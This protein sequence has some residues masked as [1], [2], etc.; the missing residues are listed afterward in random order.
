MRN[1]YLGEVNNDR[2]YD[3][4]GKWIKG[5]N[6]LYIGDFKNGRRHG[7]GVETYSDGNFYRGQFVDGKRHGYGTMVW[8][9]TQYYSGE[10]E[11]GMQNGYGT[12]VMP[13]G[14]ICKGYW[15][16]NKLKNC[17]RNDKICRQ[18]C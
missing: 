14:K 8:N 13:D 12:L 11:E 18:K 10:Y 5:E 1:K 9:S 15:F 7:S 3:G 2:K 6:S 16:N 4:L 17:P